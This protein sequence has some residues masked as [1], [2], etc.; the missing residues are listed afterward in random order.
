MCTNSNFKVEAMYY[1]IDELKI[2]WGMPLQEVRPL[3][4]PVQKYKSYMGW[5]NIRGKCNTIFGLEA[6]AF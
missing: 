5:P 1:E 4:D 3:L 6:I 2:D